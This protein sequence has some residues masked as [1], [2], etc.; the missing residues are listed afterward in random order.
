MRLVTVN[1]SFY[2]L[3]KKHG[4]EKE[5]LF[6]KDGRPCVL[7]VNLSY[8]GKC[9]DFAVPLRS[10]ISATTPFSQYL[11][12]PPR[13]DTKNGRHCGVHYVKLFPITSKYVTKYHRPLS[14]IHFQA[15]LS[16]LQSSE[17]KII[18]ACQSYL[19]RC[20]KGYRLPITPDI[21]GIISIL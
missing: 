6:N 5:V 3:C 19:R 8:K 21:D 9:Y 11:S 12:L 20:E 10:N 14:D 15:E 1:K 4:L 18:R 7:L 17:R 2:T 13:S 16:V